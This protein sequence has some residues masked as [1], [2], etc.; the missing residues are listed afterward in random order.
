MRT[1]LPTVLIPLALGLTLSGCSNLSSFASVSGDKVMGL[2]TPYRVEIV[3]GNVLTKEQV[4]RAK[5]GMTREQVRDV[6]GTPLLTDIFHT[7]RWDYTFTIRRQGTPFEQRKVVA[8]FE[9]DTLKKLDVPD[10]LPTEREFIAAIA[11]KFSA[12]SAPKLELSES[13]VKALPLPPKVEQEASDIKPE[14]RSFP[15]LESGE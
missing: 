6:L 8:W 11:P 5:P 3:Q 2:V 7:D 9:G 15:P 1:R 13:E 10:N 4:E 14:Q 12:R